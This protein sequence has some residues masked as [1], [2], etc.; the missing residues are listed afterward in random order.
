[1]VVLFVAQNINKD[2]CNIEFLMLNYKKVR[3]EIVDS[4]CFSSEKAA[5]SLSI[6]SCH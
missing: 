3:E 5:F 6:C 1:M 2:Y 4:R